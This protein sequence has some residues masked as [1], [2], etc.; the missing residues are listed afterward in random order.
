VARLSTR[1]TSMIF[2]TNRPR[3]TKRSSRPQS[4][5]RITEQSHG[6]SH[7][8]WEPCSDFARYRTFA[9]M[10]KVLFSVGI[11][12]IPSVF[13]YV[14]ALP[15]ALLVI[16]WGAFNT[17]GGFLLGA[18]RLRHPGMHVSILLYVR[19]S[20]LT[21]RR[22]SKTWLTWSAGRSTGRLSVCCMWSG[23][24][25]R[26]CRRVAESDHQLHLGRGKWFH[27]SCNGSQRVV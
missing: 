11:L 3:R 15:G 17:Y 16:G 27:R 24:S 7:L 2:T 25:F 21:R 8:C 5:G 4:M 19:E 12:S 20:P 1:P 18:F 13:S 6:A 23:R 10:F 14:G 26:R 9:L 22:V